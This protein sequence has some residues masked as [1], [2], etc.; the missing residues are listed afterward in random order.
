MVGNL[1][2][3]ASSFMYKDITF[4]EAS[5]RIFVSLSLDGQ[6]EQPCR[7]IILY[8]VSG[9]VVFLGVVAA[10]WIVACIH[11]VIKY[12]I[13]P[14]I[15]RLIFRPLD[16]QRGLNTETEQERRPSRFLGPASQR[17]RRIHSSYARGG[18]ESGNLRSRRTRSPNRS[19]H[20][21]LNDRDVKEV[22]QP[23]VPSASQK[24]RRYTP[25]EEGSSV[26]P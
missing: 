18:P 14:V 10:I 3:I 26:D 6:C 25:S 22:P 16:R 19:T 1:A 20:S 5:T 11:N 13:W 24:G 23:L 12:L 15:S 9:M 8:L 21:L 2:S 17:N 4:E 7:T